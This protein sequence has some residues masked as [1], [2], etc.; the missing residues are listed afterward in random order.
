MSHIFVFKDT[1]AGRYRL[2]YLE[3]EE[4]P[5]N[6]LARISPLICL[7]DDLVLFQNRPW[8]LVGHVPDSQRFS[9]HYYVHILHTEHI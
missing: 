7:I 6:I 9:S 3:K 4:P 1:R 2:D 5:D 8:R